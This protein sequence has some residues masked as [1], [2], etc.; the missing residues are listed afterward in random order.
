MKQIKGTLF[1]PWAISIRA[2]KSGIYDQ[3]LSE[4]DKK[5]LKDRVL[6]SLWYPYEVFKTCFNAVC[7][8]EAQENIEVIEKWGYLYGKGVLERLYKER[9]KINELK[10][11]VDSYNNLFKLWFNFGDQTGKV[12][13]DK[14]VHLTIQGL[15]KD[16]RLFYHISKGWMQGF[17]D[18]YLGTTVSAKFIEKSW[19]GSEKTTVKITWNS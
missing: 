11:A 13:S 10:S 3:Y 8:V 17:F 1:K 9:L 6:D 18:A 19:E 14:E 4:E 2:N 12:I 5:Y 16:F 15:D 7:K